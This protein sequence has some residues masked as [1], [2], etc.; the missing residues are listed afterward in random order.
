MLG[1]AQKKML[2]FKSRIKTRCINPISGR[3]FKKS[4]HAKKL[5]GNAHKW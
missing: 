3:K 1:N 4:M 5:E 2:T